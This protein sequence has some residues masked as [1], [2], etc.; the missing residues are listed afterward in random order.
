MCIYID[1]TFK[2]FVYE[3]CKLGNGIFLNQSSVLCYDCK[4]FNDFDKIHDTD[5]WI[6]GEN[7][8]PAYYKALIIADP[9]FVPGI[10]GFVLCLIPEKLHR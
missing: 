1:V 8:S 7:N 2:V 5:Q 3:Y 6:I 4:I 9:T 10:S